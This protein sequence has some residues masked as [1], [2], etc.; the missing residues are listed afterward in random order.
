MTF[1]KLEK[2]EPQ[3]YKFLRVFTG[4]MLVVYGLGKI[5]G[6]YMPRAPVGSQMW[7]GGVI[8]IVGGLLVA[9]GLP[10]LA[11]WAAFVLSG[12]MAVAYFQ[13][14]WK[15]DFSHFHWLP[16]VNQ[17]MPAVLFCFWFL[18]LFVRGP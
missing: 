6:V 10:K 15:L 3:F 9:S 13:F 4:L 8:E 14:H 17:G 18:Y 16:Q 7:I 1:A 12:E 5:V 2:Y 11:R